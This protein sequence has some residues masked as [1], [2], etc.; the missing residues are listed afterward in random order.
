[1]TA[2][3]VT[4]LEKNPDPEKLNPATIASAGVRA[5]ELRVPFGAV[6]GVS[7]VSLIICVVPGSWVYNH[8]RGCVCPNHFLRLSVRLVLM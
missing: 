7:Y 3:R 8:G 2:P 4:L 5:T 1:M 6:M